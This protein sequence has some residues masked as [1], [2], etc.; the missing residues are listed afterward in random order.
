[1]RTR[2]TTDLPDFLKCPITGELIEDPVVA[3]DG[4]TYSRKAITAHIKDNLWPWKTLTSPKTGASITKELR[5]NYPAIA[6]LDA[7]RSDS[8][9][10]NQADQLEGLVDTHFLDPIT[11]STFATPKINS[12][13]QTYSKESIDQIK[14]DRDGKKIDPMTRELFKAGDD[15][16]WDNHF[17]E[18][19]I[20]FCYQHMS[21]KGES[22]E[23]AIVAGDMDKAQRILLTAIDS[24]DTSNSGFNAEQLKIIAGD[25]S[26]IDS[27][28][29]PKWNRLFWAKVQRTFGFERGETG[30]ML[31]EGLYNA[32]VIAGQT[33]P[34]TTADLS[35]GRLNHGGS[36]NSDTLNVIKTL[37]DWGADLNAQFTHPDLGIISPL[38][39]AIIQGDAELVKFFISKKAPLFDDCLHLAIQHHKNDTSVLELLIAYYESEGLSIDDAFD[40]MSPMLYAV[41]TDNTNALKLLITHGAKINN[42][43]EATTRHGARDAITLAIENDTSSSLSTLLQF[44]SP[45]DFSI[46]IGSGRTQQILSPLQFAARKGHLQCVQQ[47]HDAGDDL[48]ATDTKGNTALHCAILHGHTDVANDLIKNGANLNAANKLGQTPLDLAALK[49]NLTLVTTLIQAGAKVLRSSNGQETSTLTKIERSWANTR[50]KIL[51]QRAI[52]QAL[53]AARDAEQ[54]QQPRDAADSSLVTRGVH[55]AKKLVRKRGGS[56]TPAAAPKTD[57][58][59]QFTPFDASSLSDNPSKRLDQLA[60]EVKRLREYSEQMSADL[61]ASSSASIAVSA[62]KREEDD[63]ANSSEQSKLI[64]Q[65]E[66]LVSAQ[67]SLIQSTKPS[68]VTAKHIQRLESLAFDLNAAYRTMG[69]NK[70]NDEAVRLVMRLKESQRYCKSLDSYLTGRNVLYCAKDIVSPADK[71]K[72]TAQVANLKYGIRR[73]ADTGDATFFRNMVDSI[74]KQ[75]KPRYMLPG[76]L[77]STLAEIKPGT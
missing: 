69:V 13:G 55:A 25:A 48:N 64:E 35:K 40:G 74:S 70:N 37:I 43:T 33:T 41:K 75:S 58:T 12:V 17:A 23:A 1:M 72:R 14:P 65:L 59:P 67:V 3:S 24:S 61:Q 10:F 71:E 4:Y 31:D 38:Q 77:Q 36:A 53:A 32:I 7:Y 18:E 51:N 56:K 63:A 27:T 26:N 34:D 66:E 50:K 39:A 49:D 15:E 30:K 11:Q 28:P 21:S 42:R 52:R 8:A 73:Y 22:A 45:K 68:A 19:G 47:L 16:Q 20:K 54:E 62:G 2:E 44:F 9:S 5:T 57:T 76:S 29:K 60:E 6:V 46:T